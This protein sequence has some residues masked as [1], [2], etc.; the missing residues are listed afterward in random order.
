MFSLNRWQSGTFVL[1]TLGMATSSVAPL[2]APAPS[3]AQSAAFSDVSSGYWAKDF[4]AQLA[5]RNVIAGFPDGTFKPE[6][7]VTRAEFAAMMLKANKYFSKARINNAVSFKDVPTTVWY[8]SAVQDANATGFLAGY[9]G[10]LFQPEQLIPREQV[11]VSLANGLNYTASNPVNNDLQTYSD[12]SSISSYARISLAA[13][14]EKNLVVNY[15]SLSVLNPTR[16]AT[17]AEVASFIYQALVSSGQATAIGSPYIV[18]LNSTQ[19]QPTQARIPSGTVIPVRYDQAKKIAVTPDEKVPLTLTVAQNVVASNGTVLIPS[20]SQVSGQLQPA[21]GG[22]QFV[23]QQLTLTT[24]QQYNLNAN[25]QVITKTQE[26]SQGTNIGTV[27]QDAALGSAAAAGIS[28]VTGNKH[29]SVGKVLTGTG[30]GTI[31]GLFLG[32]NKVKLVTIDPNTDLNLTLGSD[33]T[34]TQ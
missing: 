32:K 33:L 7:A 31:A 6:K 8:Y 4:I 18:A 15:P 26:V 30:I 2:V 19:T 5:Q 23:A 22:S 1:L 34:F 12:A 11:L 25:S 3:F 21:Q 9:P 24:G 16:N 13:A 17:R 14:T 20:G 10:N 28:A 29:I 27:L